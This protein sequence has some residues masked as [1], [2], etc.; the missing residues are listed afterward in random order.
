[1]KKKIIGMLAALVVTAVAGYIG[2]DLNQTQLECVSGV[3]V[4]M[5]VSE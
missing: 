2:V 3:V 1:M 5:A 4:E